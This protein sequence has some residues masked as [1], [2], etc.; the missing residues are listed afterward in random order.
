MREKDDG[1]D[2]TRHKAAGMEGLG[3]SKQMLE[4][5]K[6]RWTTVFQKIVFFIGNVSPEA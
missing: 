3:V 1:R 6:L 2:G 4:C 5:R